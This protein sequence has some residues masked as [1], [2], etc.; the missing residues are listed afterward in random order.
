MVLDRRRERRGD[1]SGSTASHTI[2][3]LTN[4]TTYTVR[5]RATRTDANAG[6]YSD[7]AMDAP[8]A[9]G[10]T[11]S[12]T[13]LTVTEQDSNGD[14][15]TVVLNTQPTA[16]VVVTVAGHA[17]TD[18]L[19]APT[20][21]TFTTVNWETA[22]TVTVT[23]VN[24]ADTTNDTVSL[25]HS[26]ASTDT[27][28]DGITIAGVT[29]TVEDNDTAQVT[30]VMLTP[31]DGEL[32][33]AWAPVPNATGYEVQWKS[34]GQG[35]NTSGRQATIGSGSTASHTISSL[36]NG[37]TYTVRV[38][39]TR[40]DANAGPYS[41]EAMDAPEAA[42]VTVSETA[43]TVTEQDSN[44]DSYTVVLNTQPTANV[45]VTVAG[46]AGTD[47]LPAPTTLTFTTV[48]WETAQT[49]TV[50]AVNDRDRRQRRGHHQ[51]YTHSAASTDTDYDG[52]TIAGVTVTVEDNDTAQVTGVMLTPGDGELVV[53]WAPV[54]NATGYEV[55]WKSG[56]QGYNTS[57]RQA[58]I[59]SGS[60]AS[61]TI[62]SL[63]NG[64]TYTVRVRATRTD[65]NAG[66]Y[67]DEAMDA[68]EA[69]GVTVSET[70]L[71]VTE[72][73]SNGDS[74]TVVLNTQPTANVV[75]T[76]AGHAGTDVLPA[77]TTLTFTTVNWE[78]AQT[79]TVTAVNDADTTNDTVSLTHSAASTD[80]DY[81]GITIAGVTVTVED[82]DT[83]QV[84]GVMLTPGD[85]ELVVAWAPLANAT[86]YEVQW[87]SG[88]QGYNTSG[89]QATI[90]L[91]S[92]TSHT[93]PSLTNGT[94]YTVRVRA[95]RTGANAGPYS[96]EA[97]DAPEA[98]GVTVSE[99]ALTVTE[100][101]TTGDSYTV[102]LDSQ[103]TANVVVT[104]AGHLGTDV[105]PAPTTLTFTLMNWETAQT[106]TVTA[107][108]DADTTND[109]VSLTH[110]AASTD[111]D[112]NGITIA[113]VTVTVNDDDTANSAP[114]FT[115]AATFDAAENQTAV[116][117]V[118]A[119]D[120]DADDSVTGYTI[121]GG[122]DRS[123]FSI[124]EAS[125][126]LTFASAPNF[127]APADADADNAYVVVVRAASGTGARAKTADQT[128]TVTVT[129]VAGEAPGVPAVPTVSAAGVTS[130]TAGW[131]APA[132]A[133][134][135]VTDYDYRYR[136]T[137]PQGSWTEVTGT[138]ITALSA[139][140]TGLAEDTGYDVQVRATNA[141]GT[142]GWSDSGSGSTDAN[143]APAFTSAATFDAAENQTAVGTVAASDGDADDS[144]T[145]Y[146]IQGGADRS[147]FSIVEASG[148]L[149]FASA[150]NF[151]A[152]ADADADNAYVVVVR[153]ASGTGARAKTA[154][155][156]ITVTVTDVA[157]E[158]P[159]VPAVPT[160]SAAGVTSVTAG[161]TAPAN[162]GPP[163]T[164]YDYRYRVTSP[165]GSWTEVTGTAITALSATITGLAEDTGYDVQV[166]ATNAE[167][168]SGW[169][170]SGSGSTDA[171][172]APAF[173][174][175]ATFDAAENQTAVGT[176]AASDGDADDSVTGYTIQGGAD[177]SKFSI[178]EASG[179]L[180]F[181]SAPNF[182]APA[183][184]DA[185]N[186]YVVVVRAASGTGAR[187]KTADQTI[188]VT[189][190]D[191][192][193]E[194]PG[195][196][197]VP[198]VS[199]AGVTSVTAGWTAP[200][201]AGP[202]VT[203][204]D[205][206]YRVTSPQGSWTEVTGTAI[207]ALSATI[208]GLAEDTGYDV[209]VRATNA[210][211]TSGWSDSGSGSTDANAAP[212]FT[213]AATFDAAENQTAVGTVAASDGDA[214]DSVTGY[215]IQG[216]AD[217]SKFS[218]VEASGVLTF[219]SAPNFE[220]PA[221]AD[222]DNA[223][224]V[225]VRAAS[226]TGARAK[227]AD[228]TIT[229][230]VTDVAG[231]APGVPAVPTVSAAGVTSVTA[232]WTAPANAGPPVTD[233]DYRYRVTS[234]QGSWTEVTGTAITALSATITGLAEDTGY[235][236]QVRATNAEGTSGW[237][238]SG[239]G[240]TDANAAPA[241]TSAATFDAAENQ[242]AV[243]TVAA[244][245]GDADDSVTGYTIQ[246]GADRSK[247]SIVEASGVLTFASAPNF[248]APA[249]ADADNAYVVV[250]RAASG[251]GARAKTADQTITVTVTDVAGEAP[252]VPAVPTV[253]AAGVTSVTAGWTAP[254][255]AG[256]PVTDYDYR[257][258]VTSPQGSWTEVTGTA[259]TALSATITGLA[260]DTGYDV[261]VRATNAEGTSGWSDS[262]SGSTDANAAP[263]FTSAATFDAAEN[264]TAVGTVAASDGDADD[265]V[266]GYTIQGGAD[267][268]KFSIVEAS[269]VL[270]FASAPNF[271]A[272]ADAD[273]DNAY[274]VV[275]RAASG[276][277]ARAKTAD[278][279]I[280]VTVTDVAGE[281]PGV[282]AVPTVS[283][284]GVTSVT[285]GWT[286]PANAGPPVTD[287]DYRYRVTSPQGS[288][289]EVTGTAITALSATITGLAEDTGYDV[290]V[291]AT[292]A[293]GTSG[294]SDSGSG[295]T[296]ANAAPAF[297]SA[298][299]F[300]AAENQTAVGTVAASDGDA[301]DSV[302]GYT[303]QGGADRSKF[304]IVEASGVLTFA[305]A[306]NFEAPADAD[307]DNAYVVVVRAA[308]G[309]GARAKTADQ[310]ITV[311][312]TDVAGEAPGVPA[313]PTVSAAGVTSVTAGWTAPANAGPP[314]T[315]YD[316]R[317]RVTSPQGS[318]T[319]V[320]G[321]A[322]TALSATITGLAEDTGYDV[323]VRA[324]NAEGTSGWSDSGSGSTD[325][326]AAPAFTSAATFDAAENQTAVGT[327]AASDGDADDSVTGYTIQGGADRSKFSI[328]EASGVLTFASAPNFEAPADAD[329]DN[330]YVVVVRAASGTGARA[331]TAD[332]TITVTVTDVAGEAPGVPAVPTVSA[333]GVTSVTAGWT[334]PANAGPPVTDYDYRYRVTSPQGSWT[335]VTG[336]AITALS[337]TI[338]GLAEDTGYDVQVRAT[339]AEGTS[340]WSDSGSGSTDANAAPAFTSAATF[341]AAENQTAVGTVAAS[342]GDA[343]DS[344]TGYTIQGGA[345][346]SKFSIV[347][348]S[349]VLTF[350]SA[351]NFEA[352]ADA[353]AD[354]A[355]VVVVRA[356]SGTG[357]RAKTADQT[358][359]V[360]VTDVA[361]EAP[362]VP[363]VP[364]V[365]AAG[366]TSVTAGWTAPANAGPPVTDY[367]YRYR[368]TSPQ[369]SWTEV[370]GT[371]I[372]ALSATI[373][374]LAEDTGYDVQV[375]ATNAEGTSG[376]S[377]SGSGS[378][379]ANAAPA[380]TSA[381]TFDAAEN[382]TA[383]GTVAA[384]DGDADDSVTGYTIQ[385]GADRSKFSI[386]EASGVLTFASA[387]N[388][389]APADADAD[390]AYVVVVRAASGTGARA[391]TADQTITVTVTDVAGEAPGVP[392]VPTVSA[393]G[394][395]SVTAGWTA[396][397]NA[398]P[399]VTDYD[400][401]YRVT[402]PQ[403]SWTEVTGTAITALSATIT[404]LAEDTGYD[405]QVRATNAEGTSGW[406]DSGSGSTDANAAPAFT[407]AATF[408]A[409]ENQTAVGTVAASDGDADDSVTGYTIQGGA[410][411]S[412]FSI[413]EASGVL[414]FASAPNFEAPAD[415]DADNAYVVVVR[416]ASGTGARAKT[417]DQTI[418]VTVTDVA[419]EAPGVPAVPTV[420]AAG[421]TSVT[422]GWTAPANAGP[423][424]TDYDYRY[425]VTSP[426]GSWTE[427]TGTAITALSATITGLAEDTGY[428]VQVRATNAEGTS[429][430]SA[431]GSGSTDVDGEA[432]GVR[433]SKTALTV[434][435]QDTTGDSY[436]V[437]LDSQP[438]ADVT[439]A[440]GGHM[441]TDVN[442]TPASLTF[443]TMNWETVQTVTV[444]AVN[445]ADTVNDT[446]SL[447]HTATSTDTDY[448]GI[449]IAGV[450]VTVN[451]NDTANTAPTFPSSTAMRSVAENTAAGQNVGAV[452]TATDSDGDTLTYTLEGTDAASF[453][454]VTTT[455]P[456]AQIRT[457]SGVTYNHEAKSTYTVVVKA[458]DGN[459]GTDT[460][461]VTISITDV[462]DGEL[463]LEGGPST[464]E[465]RLEVFHDGEW[466]TVCD[467]QF[468]KQVDDPRTLHD[469]R[470]IS[471]LAPQK[472]CQF[473][474]Y[475]TGE[476]IPRGS[477]SM[478]PSAQ[479]I[480]L[481]DVRCLDNRP[482]WT[483]SEPTKL[484]HCYHAGWGLNNCTHD[485]DV[486]LRCVEGLGMQTEATAL[487]ASF[488]DMPQSHDGSGVFTFR[489]AFSEDVDIGRLDM[490]DHALT[491][492]GGTVKRAKRVDGRS[493]LWEFR[494]EPSGTDPVS[495]LVPQD[496]ACTE[497][498]ALCTADG[499][500][501]TTGL[502]HSVPGPAP[503]P[504]G[505]A[506]AGAA[507]GELRVGAGRA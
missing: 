421:V 349:G 384:S 383:V 472:A 396:P 306:P 419:G 346:R 449:T 55:Q 172:A 16:N 207:T 111:T 401:R 43:L 97:M 32:V 408:D 1:G 91:G 223:Y 380:F 425:R 19:P 261:Q 441:S 158:A 166:R 455:D 233:Y 216:G 23:A 213:S 171:N 57:G 360:T 118:A 275:V 336:T 26:A 305:S 279:T 99:T 438:T 92:T 344:V 435:E 298:A 191:V 201:N 444:K 482:H 480:W 492:T 167:G 493:D 377:D 465:G 504:A 114:A 478:A 505:P 353:D 477:I 98:A 368:V 460:V 433:V 367:D 63:T 76:V 442:P 192:A 252:G 317:Y 390:N 458:D 447:T 202:P 321:T 459:S 280:T 357:A 34:G 418:T 437:V 195:V 116:G 241:F 327:V 308:S 370:T 450:T 443:T 497:T 176:V 155:Q 422:A 197:A 200:A 376:W 485:E 271:E 138:A 476:V 152:P 423:P 163:V 453:D 350:A 399:P 112:Y 144:V 330:A 115:S 416:A 250:V 429:G 173:T 122:A 84:T 136:V 281:A 311:T 177:R 61:H 424:V 65:A 206:R 126:V 483:G 15:Y 151:E 214:D 42:G 182:E 287:Y 110:S 362:G 41:D 142:S 468:D 299:T 507:R 457:K 324:T 120:G 130:V 77:P 363:A 307:A 347:E 405:V 302:T 137:S 212:A 365:S 262:G 85:G 12:E 431:S 378:T 50:T 53:A 29:V 235:D 248:E 20:T 90:S 274:V 232:G 322:I 489:I 13:A 239:S 361:G 217:R 22:Q 6:P 259:I 397:A 47:V 369:G 456:A 258:R 451:D 5:V 89:R 211:G 409:A 439:I 414:T 72:Q 238:D 14:S 93:I 102:V 66:P 351:P 254:A 46:H 38:R 45:V 345:D 27:D 95:T 218:I 284:A 8:E 452:L 135:P 140:I 203:D 333:A 406:S 96:D 156:T 296:D 59:G 247:F 387:P 168:T 318:W 18:V 49:V 149:T 374:G 301:D 131:T 10:V 412:K 188:T 3:S 315:D 230:T 129:D 273:A 294:W 285:A 288:W 36:T 417:A 486:H 463:R 256:P 48:N 220:A 31:G 277:G 9:A 257:Y 147:K 325:A 28:Y 117:T 51:R 337:A 222:A 314:V 464:T 432:P 79:V 334:A 282:P 224:V 69:A 402:S 204:Y 295:S 146:T 157:G 119:S 407:S 395:T 94:T 7:E 185:D 506:G 121:Q 73:D 169:S 471:N 2:S 270:T 348:A 428:D 491:V 342:D 178:V 266:T 316:Y 398:G 189:V 54:P 403:G 234:P 356:A 100:E 52:I 479:Q 392:A 292:N 58:T 148:V 381:A 487:T 159:G 236:V 488:E 205:Y 219:A 107:V 499:Q 150:P 358:I 64:T 74:Y 78:T 17:G 40:T 490:K 179:V 359:T 174:S 105:L 502:G 108:N 141:E 473:M 494:V 83:A 461:T 160:V 366:V 209:Q 310:T 184:A 153:A 466:G 426:Q 82:N 484:H 208:T 33:V 291:R 221:D 338:T 393:A 290:Q 30:G 278:Q 37:T 385:G 225:V 319:E 312:V 364:T 44:G 391:K 335:E 372:T 103:P 355:Y 293:E 297:T 386:V 420:S 264:Q 186:A 467:D 276:T 104:V 86:G 35:Y 125:G 56:G 498:G 80:T 161:W 343:D 474:G 237:S 379:D 375:R 323:Q 415:A 263:A 231:E 469:R 436:T 481:D 320:T 25:T 246:G 132:N 411:R 303:I 133:G 269:G 124:V 454:L 304:S 430:W 496:R 210:E 165:Q 253:S 194:A 68:P 229:V 70:A 199:A 289:T 440:V 265:S 244:S 87:K 268:S 39:A 128:I 251:T 448:S 242:T 196:P 139:T 400:Y 24:D 226:G 21:L 388:F 340:G 475:A 193:G 309:T 389:E 413:V 190:T 187:A 260:E 354:N 11:V 286:A 123:K 382:Q 446:V 371:A 162:A 181:A 434:T 127:E 243:G 81:D 445:D 427:V 113:G 329:A 495:I 228:Q 313:V 470:R 500:M 180:T 227:T 67:S 503:E 145:G 215:T 109:T 339:N 341:D 245:D 4:G 106:V 373:T 331:K 328:V 404:G 394:V 462:D 410:D 170:D 75:V 154:D 183:D 164:D 267:R 198:T 352:P 283:A 326:N 88:G 101:D 62:S 71:T 300:D 332:Q 272:P 501:L 143:A 175:A 249:D 60:T 134:P 240:S 255:N